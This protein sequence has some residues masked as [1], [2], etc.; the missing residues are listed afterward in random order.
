MKKRIFSL[1]LCCAMLVGLIPTA[2][3]AEST[4]GGK[5]L[6]QEL[7]EE[8]KD[9]NAKSIMLPA[10]DYY[11]A[12][13]VFLVDDDADPNS[14]WPLVIECDATLDL[15]GYVLDLRGVY[16]PVWKV[17]ADRQQH[18]ERPP[19]VIS[20]IGTAQHAASITVMQRSRRRLSKQ[21]P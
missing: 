6:T 12:E 1:L 8:N 16:R 4:P 18:K 13:N 21:T 9:K 11:L 19:R 14:A 5:V 10:G 17:D 2:V 7:I 15:N 20:S 3:F